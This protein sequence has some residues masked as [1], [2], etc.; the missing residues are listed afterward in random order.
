MFEYFQNAY[1]P[2]LMFINAVTC[3]ATIG[4]VDDAC[5]P[6]QSVPRGS[7][8]LTAQAFN[9]LSSSTDSTTLFKA[10]LRDGFVSVGERLERLSAK[11]AAARRFVSAGEKLLRAT[12]LF[13]T[14]E[15]LM[16]DYFDPAKAAMFDRY[17]ACFKKAIRYGAP[18]IN[19]IEFVSIPFEG[20]T[21]EGAFLPAQDRSSAMP[22]VI[23][24]NGGHGSLEWPQLVGTAAALARRGIA[25]LTFDHPGNGSARYHKGLQYRYD[26]ESFAKAAVDYLET[27]NDVD[28]S[29]IG[30]CGASLGGYYAPRAA[31][32]EKRLKVC[33][34]LGAFYEYSL[35]KYFGDIPPSYLDDPAAEATL[36]AA[37]V[38]YLKQMRWAFGATST[39]DLFVKMSKFSLNGLMGEIRVPFLILHGQNDSQVPLLNADR[40]IHEAVNSPRAQLIVCGPEDG[41]DQH[42]SLDN[43][44][45]ALNILADWAADALGVEGRSRVERSAA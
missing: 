41:G 34:V 8:A 40:T 7:A 25:S 30:V 18:R 9:G 27:R 6:A 29:R 19:Q 21:L 35:A 13:V 20:I 11:D 42:C 17:R 24:M 3:G 33:L 14:A 4:D 31:A 32:L 16:D 5:R 10:S 38:T 1:W 39:R 15:M 36:P 45:T 37:R 23:H 26:S 43:I 12:A 2:N 28:R 44:A 22:A